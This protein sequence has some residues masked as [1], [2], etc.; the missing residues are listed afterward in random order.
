[1][2][3][4]DTESSTMGTLFKSVSKAVNSL[5]TSENYDLLG[6]DKEIL[7][8]LVENQKK[9]SE[10]NVFIKINKEVENLINEQD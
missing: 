4:D 6:Q 2:S 3:T 1:M 10:K 5:Y 7:N 8:N 9:H